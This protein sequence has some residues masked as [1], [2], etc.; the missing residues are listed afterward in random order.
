MKT[1]IDDNWYEDFFQGLNCELWE[2]A[3]S[4]QLTKEEVDFLV[5]ELNVQQGQHLLDIPCG[6]GRHSIEF[7]KRGFNVTGVDISQ[8]FIQGLTEKINA[9]K[10]N[11][12]TIQADILTIQLNEIF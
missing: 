11:I 8:T 3:V 2:K 9:Y 4:P 10:L 5:S 1:I 12:K 6:F 7:A